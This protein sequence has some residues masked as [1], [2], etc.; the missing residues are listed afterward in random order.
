MKRILEIKP[1]EGGRDSQLFIH[2][3]AIAY[4]NYFNRLG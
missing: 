1:A 2:D 3:L 4:E